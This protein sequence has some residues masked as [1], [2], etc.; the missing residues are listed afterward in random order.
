MDSDIQ[1]CLISHDQ[2]LIDISFLQITQTDSLGVES[3]DVIING[4]GEAASVIISQDNGLSSGV[5][6]LS[7][8]IFDSEA[9]SITLFGMATGVL[10]EISFQVDLELPN[11]D[12]QAMSDYDPFSEMNLSTTKEV[13]TYLVKYCIMVLYFDFIL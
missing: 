12:S 7:S 4:N 3:T 11:T 1:V 5:I 8:D 10:S 13:G 2:D 9:T 6:V